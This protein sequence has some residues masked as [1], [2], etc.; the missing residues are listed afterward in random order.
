MKDQGEGTGKEVRP[1]QD[2]VVE[3]VIGS[4]QDP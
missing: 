4:D 2:C 3:L 1:T